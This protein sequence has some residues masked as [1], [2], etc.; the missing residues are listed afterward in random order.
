MPKYHRSN[1]GV[2]AE[3]MA[4]ID[5]R[6]Q[7]EYGIPQGVLMA[8]AGRFASDV[9][10]ADLGELSDHKIA[11]FC[12]KGNNGGDG[13]VIAKHLADRSPAELRV[14]APQEEKIRRGAAYDNFVTARDMG[15]RIRPLDEFLSGEDPAAEYT[16][17]VDSIFGTGFKGE[18]PEQFAALGR[19]LNSSGMKVFAVDVPTGLD[20][21]TGTA[22]K[23][24]IKAYKTISFG[25]PKKGF[26]LN[27]GPGVSGKVVVGNIGFPEAL[28]ESYAS[29]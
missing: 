7:E 25:L 4:R 22:S 8:N 3:E 29:Q 15:I 21:T 2:S 1:K 12:G 24:C 18:L 16:V 19:I 5:Q 14:Y 11:V 10:I 13:F 28:L 27:D 6:A 20:A 26:Y 9:I 17:A 23:D